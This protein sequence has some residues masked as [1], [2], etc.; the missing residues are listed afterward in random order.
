MPETAFLAALSAYLSGPAAL[1]PAP[2]LLGVIEPALAAELP[3][4]VLSLDEVHRLGAGL[5]ERSQLITAGALPWQANIDLANP[6]LPAESDFRLLSPDRLQLILPHG[7]LKQKDGGDGAF[8]SADIA[9]RLG[10]VLFTVVDAAP[11][12]T[13]VS[14]DPLAGSL[15][16]GAPLPA[17]GTLRV[18]YVLGQWERRVIPIAG[19]IRVDVYGADAGAAVAL[20][21]AAMQALGNATGTE[22]RGLRKLALSQI[23]PVRASD[24]AH[25]SARLRSARL[26]FDYEHEMNRPDSS[27]GVI[28]TIQIGTTLEAARS[29]GGTVLIDS[30]PDATTKVR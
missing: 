24:A 9:V 10:A 29:V 27:G 18:D 12:A 3:A 25:A 17:T 22:L 4:V 30:F 6:V 13:E 2:A 26:V 1:S 16:F 8:G 14:V 28:R 21:A 20:S 19:V 7:G 5:G 23:G 15:R 11:A